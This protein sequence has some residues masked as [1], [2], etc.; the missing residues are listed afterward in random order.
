MVDGRPA[1]LISREG[2]PVLVKGFMSGY[3]FK[4]MAIGGD[5]RFQDKPNKNKYS[6]PHDA[7]QYR[8]MPFAS[9]RLVDKPDKPKY[10]PFANNT[11]FRWTN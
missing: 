9:E 11:V 7:L 2:A 4:R 10:D 8:L 5:E 1:F 6:H 3:H